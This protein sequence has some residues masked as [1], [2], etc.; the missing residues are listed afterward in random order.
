MKCIL[1]NYDICVIAEVRSNNT[2]MSYEVILKTGLPLAGDSTSGDRQGTTVFPISTY[3]NS[4][5]KRLKNIMAG[6]GRSSVLQLY[7]MMLRESQKFTA[8]NFRLDLALAW[9]LGVGG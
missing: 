3:S 5:E 9:E 8:Y 7:K 4:S 6:T 2:S 1:M